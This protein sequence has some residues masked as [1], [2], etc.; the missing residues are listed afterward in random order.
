MKYVTLIA[1]LALS[2]PAHAQE[3]QSG[4]Q[5]ANSTTVQVMAGTSHAPANTSVEHS[6]AVYGTPNV[7]GSYFGGSNGCLVG[8]GGGIA[9]GPVGFSV[10]IGR[11]DEGCDRRNNA[12]ALKALGLQNAAIALM[13]QDS[14]V[15]DA[16]FATHGKVCPG[17][18]RKR[19]GNAEYAVLEA[20]P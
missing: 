5:A 14:S 15:A 10:N 3:S 6:G 13:C 19:Y 2:F 16:F 20:K 12:A 8:T 17:V 7:G 1:A 11:N 18:D 9:G 4:A